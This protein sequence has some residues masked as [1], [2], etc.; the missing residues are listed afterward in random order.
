M[1]KYNYGMPTDIKQLSEAEQYAAIKEYAEGSPELED[2]LLV[3]NKNG[4]HT[5]TCCRGYHKIENIQEFITNYLKHMPDDL[6]LGRCINCPYIGF[7][8]SANIFEY[9]SADFI[10][11]PNIILNSNEYDDCIRFSGENAYELIRELTKE[12]KSGKKN[13]HELIQNKLAQKKSIEFFYNSFMQGLIRSGMSN[14]EISIIKRDLFFNA[15]CFTKKISEEEFFD[16]YSKF[17]LNLGEIEFVKNRI[18]EE[19]GEFYS[20]QDEN[21][22]KR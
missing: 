1:E 11:N 6:A 17:G 5:R 3:A 20:L 8:K 9:L 4:L 7:E 19:G 22:Q 14:D 21:V 13:N 2:C 18:I 15:C 12:I 16:L 10:N